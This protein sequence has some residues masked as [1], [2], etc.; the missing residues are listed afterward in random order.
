MSRE[1]F[2]VTPGEATATYS[3]G[4]IGDPSVIGG[5]HEILEL[6]DVDGEMAT[7]YFGGKVVAEVWPDGSLFDGDDYR[8]FVSEAEEI[9]EPLD[10]I[11]TALKAITN[12]H[13]SKEEAMAIVE[14]NF[15]NE[16]EDID[17]W[18]DYFQEVAFQYIWGDIYDWEMKEAFLPD[19]KALKE[20]KFILNDKLIA[21][22]GKG[23]IK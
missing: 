8:Y 10:H 9:E 1:F 22:A 17:D 21:E 19:F 13:L 3:R 18:R 11:N 2:E 15:I 4:W 23:Y 6:D 20:G 16:T 12:E 5:T 14:Y 7:I